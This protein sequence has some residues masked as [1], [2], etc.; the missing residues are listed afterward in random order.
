MPTTPTEYTSI[1]TAAQ[2]D[3]AIEEVTDRLDVK[4][5]WIDKDKYSR[6]IIGSSESIWN[7]AT[8]SA[9][10]GIYG[11]LVQTA[12][13][14]T[15]LR[16]QSRINGTAKTQIAVYAKGGGE[17]K[18][19]YDVL[20]NGGLLK[21]GLYE[22]TFKYPIQVDV[23][24]VICVYGYSGTFSIYY[25]SSGG[26]YPVSTWTGSVPDSGWRIY[27]FSFVLYT[28]VSDN[29]TVYSG[30]SE[31]SSSVGNDGDIYIQTS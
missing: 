29:V 9:D 18:G 3:A 1:Y 17:R 24:D 30:S 10:P 27:Q 28:L 31:P 7:D 13:Y 11:A 6:H 15:A 8:S 26:D 2:I 23:D 20:P 21:Q 22:Y 5:T 4:Q 19:L 12:G 25:K 16:I 14:V